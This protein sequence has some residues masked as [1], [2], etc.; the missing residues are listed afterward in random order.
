MQVTRRS[1]I[2]MTFSLATTPSWLSAKSGYSLGEVEKRLHSGK[3]IEGMTKD[4]LPTPSLLVDL[5]L[6]ESN[7]AK[8]SQHANASSIQLRPH[9]KTHKC[10]EIA[11]L[12]VEA[13]ALGVCTSTIHEAEVMSAA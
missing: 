13:G 10:P 2:G 11:R 12:Q 5:D 9:A 1:W 6:L 8:M 3:G 7:I 4:D